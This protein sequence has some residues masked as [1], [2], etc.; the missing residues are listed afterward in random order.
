MKLKEMLDL[1]QSPYMVSYRG[2]E[3]NENDYLES[4][5]INLVNIVPK[6]EEPILVIEVSLA[7]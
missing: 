7:I 5:V 4:T 6:N 3:V 1:I 2:Q